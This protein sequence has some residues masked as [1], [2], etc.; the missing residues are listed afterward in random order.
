MYFF[1]HPIL[2]YSPFPSFFLYGLRFPLDYAVSFEYIAL[3]VLLF[4]NI[5]SFFF[6]SFSLLPSPLVGV[7]KQRFLSCSCLIL[8][9][10]SD[11]LRLM[12]GTIVGLIIG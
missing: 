5:S 3:W 7:R 6:F 10:C 9:C 8:C 1:R 2:N 12:K 4:L 11:F